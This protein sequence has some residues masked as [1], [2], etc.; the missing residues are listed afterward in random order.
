[1]L[2]T[3]HGIVSDILE[4]DVAEGGDGTL[5]AQEDDGSHLST[6][7]VVEEEA[8]SSPLEDAKRQ[9]ILE[10]DRHHEKLEV[11]D[12]CLPAEIVLEMNALLETL[13]ETAL[14]GLLREHDV[15]RAVN[16]QAGNW[17]LNDETNLNPFWM[18]VVL[19]DGV[20]DKITDGEN[21]KPFFG[22]VQ[23]SK[24]LDVEV[25]AIS[26]GA[27]HNRERQEKAKNKCLRIGEEE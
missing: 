17:K 8:A 2:D 4:I 3:L 21:V 14:E 25:G 20:T 27:S 9:V 1:L 22:V 7:A 16:L 13:I 10:E 5:E 12:E 15:P 26:A 18:A 6:F 19:A 24:L 23:K 11:V